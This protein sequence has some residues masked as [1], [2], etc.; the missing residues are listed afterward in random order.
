M[1]LTAELRPG[2]VVDGWQVVRALRKGGFG[3][4]HEVAKHGKSFALK[5]ALHGEAHKDERQTHARTLREVAILLMLTHPNIIKPRAYGHLP[6]G[7]VYL[8]L[9]Y[10]E[11]WTM[12]EWLE[13]THPTA[14]ELARVFMKVAAALAYMHSR[15][16]LHRDLKLSNVLIRKSDGE[17]VIIDLGCATYANAEE[18]TATPL[19][20]GTDRYRTPEALRFPLKKGREPGERYPFQVAD[21]LFA[22][23]VML[24][25]LLTDPVPTLDN[26]RPDFSN[27]VMEPPP[28]RE[29]NPRV[30][31]ALS[32]LV[33]DLLAR[34]P[35]L[36]PESAEALRRKLAELA[37]HTE[38]EYAVQFHPPSEQR[39]PAPG[40]R[41]PEV[42]G[43]PAEGAARLWPWRKPLA[44][45]GMVAAVILAAAVAS[46]LA[47]REP[48][49]P[50][51]GSELAWPS[52]APAANAASQEEGSTVKKKPDA[53]TQALAPRAPQSAPAPSDPGFSA[54]CRSVAVAIATAAGCTSTHLGPEPFE[55]EPGALDAMKKELG[56]KI[57][58]RFSIKLDDRGPEYGAHL[59]TPGPVVGV[60][61]PASESQTLAP[62]GTRFY[63]KVYITQEKTYSGHP[64]EIIAVYNRVKVP[65]HEEL[66]VCFV[67][68]GD[69]VVPVLEFTKDGRAKATIN[70][71]GSPVRR[72]P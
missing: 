57:G 59:Y 34:D 15:G 71:N 2:A 31:A 53:P 8:V 4:V 5:L 6:D 46:W 48:P 67:I 38:P 44:L 26:P 43:A 49:R 22:V 23:G 58:D 54:W 37:E 52:H 28:P 55:C 65:G 11:G 3:A 18:L 39:P 66:P 12:G 24:Y 32:H 10:V 25:E 9:E 50:G 33:M 64:G 45:A 42:G 63:G 7:R 35:T 14:K 29:V 62:P 61:T 21:E 17:P 13:R 27:P 56:W 72:W 47:P 20:P 19:P 30:P 36:R 60:V 70:A 1:N 16:V 69:G 68:G 41:A 51:H 40:N